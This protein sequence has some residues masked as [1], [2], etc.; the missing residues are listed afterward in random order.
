[1][2]KISQNDFQNFN[3]KGWN[4]LIRFN[5]LFSNTSLP[6]D[7]LFMPNEEKLQLLTDIKGKK[8]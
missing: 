1:M 4:E 6:E 7:G 2:R 5:K 8:Y 3:K